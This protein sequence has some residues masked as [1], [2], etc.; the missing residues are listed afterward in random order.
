MIVIFNIP[1][2]DLGVGR[3]P[4][5]CQR[6]TQVSASIKPPQLKRAVAFSNDRAVR[7]LSS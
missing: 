4:A 3:E 7:M 6:T 2:Y 5:K 1:R